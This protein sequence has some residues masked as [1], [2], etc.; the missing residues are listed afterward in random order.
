LTNGHLIAD[1]ARLGY[2]RAEWLTL[3]PTYGK[4]RWWTVWQPAVLVASDLYTIPLSGGLGVDFRDLSHDDSTFDAVAFD[5][6]YKLN[7]TPTAEVDGQYGVDVV[8]SWRERHELIR[9]GLAECAR[10]LRSKGVLLLK[11]Q[12]QVCSGA[13]RWQTDEFTTHAER[14]GLR[15][16]DRLDFLTSSRPQPPRSRADGQPSVQQ[17]ARRNYST[18]LVF[19]KGRAT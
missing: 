6:P 13:V 8:R 4:G 1:V 17:H 14:L 19:E 7:G 3:D 10:V 11:C 9:D 18:L 15:K 2:L 12:D 16:V 5:S